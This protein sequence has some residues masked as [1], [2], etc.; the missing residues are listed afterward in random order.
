PFREGD[1]D[2]RQRLYCV[3]HPDLLARR[4]LRDVAT[5]VQPFGAVLEAPLEPSCALV[6]ATHQDQEVV[7]G[8]IDPG[9]EADDRAV[10]LVDRGVAVGM[11]AGVRT[12]VHEGAPCRE[13]GHCYYIQLR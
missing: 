13:S 7:G 12:R 10:E 5:I 3:R 1:R 2:G 9:G 11:C 4:A 8:R 6:E